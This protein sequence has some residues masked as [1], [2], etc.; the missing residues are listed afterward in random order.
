M[1]IK[2]LQHSSLTDNIFY[3]SMLA[4][5][6]AYSPS[7]EDIL[8][9]EVL[10]SSQAS[11]TFSS[12]DTLAAG[13]QHLQIRMTTRTDLSG[14]EDSFFINFNDD[15]SSNYS[16]HFMFGNGSSVNVGQNSSTTGIYPFAVSGNTQASGSFGAHIIDIVDAFEST[17]NTTIRALAGYAGGTNRIA[18]ASGMWNNTSSIQSLALDPSSSNWT[19]GSRF[20]LIG[21]K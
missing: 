12:L 17:K 19:T 3:R 18:L 1:A 11:V 13:Y 6:T 5:N 4:G 14:A 2:S 15:F 21:L 7:D 10:T 20:T 16:W 9:E 8:A